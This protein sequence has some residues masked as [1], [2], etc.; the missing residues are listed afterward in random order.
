MCLINNSAHQ[1]KWKEIGVA[2]GSI[3]HSVEFVTPLFG[4]LSATQPESDLWQNQNS[5]PQPHH[6]R[7]LGSSSDAMFLF[8]FPER[9]FSPALRAPPC[10]H[11]SLCNWLLLKPIVLAPS[12]VTECGAVNNGTVGRFNSAVLVPMRLSSFLALAYKHTHT[13]LSTEALFS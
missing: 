12:C 9:F 7:L 8:Y 3:L 4:D 5:F 2:C 13:C 1:N 10:G 11:H 6:H